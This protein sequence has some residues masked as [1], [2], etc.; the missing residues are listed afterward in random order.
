[1]KKMSEVQLDVLGCNRIGNEARRLRLYRSAL[2][3]MEQAAHRGTSSERDGAVTVSMVLFDWF[4]IGDCM[5]VDDC[6]QEDAFVT[7]R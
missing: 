1:M 2:L 5:Q 7:I 4:R 3:R 6:L